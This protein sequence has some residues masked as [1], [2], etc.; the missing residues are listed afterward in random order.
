MKR[1]AI[2]MAASGL[3]S[4]GQLAAQQA[5]DAT[6]RELVPD[7][8]VQNPEDWASQGVPATDIPVDGATDL[9]PDSPLNEM[10]L[11]DIPWPDDADFPAIQPLEPEML[12]EE[13]Q[14]LEFERRRS[15]RAQ[16]E[17]RISRELVLVFPA[18]GSEEEAFPERGDL[19]DRFRSLSTIQRLD[20]EGNVG[21]LAAQAVEDEELLR[22]LLRIYGY[23]DADV[24]RSVI[25]DTTADTAAAA[26][27]DG[28]RQASVRFDILPGQQY[29]VGAIE[30]GD[31]RAAGDD[32]QKLRETF[33]VESGDP[34]S[35]DRIVRGQ[36]DLD[37]A[38]GEA[39]YPF[40]RIAEPELVVDHARE[41]G[42]LTLDVTPGGKYNFGRV[43]SSMPD[44]LSGKHLERIA[45]FD[46]GDLYQRSLEFDLRQA[47]VATGLVGTA[48]VTAVET[49]PPADG[50]PGTVDM[51]VE[52]TP[53]KLRTLAGSIG[54]GSGE[55]FKLQGS[56][57]H[58][59]LFPPEGGLRLRGIAGTREQLAGVTLSKRNFG[60]RDRILTLDA[61]ASTIDFQSY[62]ARTTSVIG[63]FERVSNLLFQK[64]FTYGIGLELVA[65]QEAERKLG[66]ISGP[67][68][69]YFVA[70]VPGQ[71]Q[72]DTS[73]DLLDPTRGYRIGLSASPEYS[74]TQSS[75]F[76]YLKLQFDLAG[77][78]PT[79]DSIVLAGRA[80]AGTIIGAPL[81]AIAPS[82]RFYAGGGGSVRG[83]AYKAIGERA[84]LDST[85]R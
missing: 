37:Q 82:R 7:S 28:Q 26:R 34:L 24:I 77:Y 54:F 46:E 22:R 32:F 21:R 11:I 67:R 31:L 23:Y 78:L 70:A 68:L 65:T 17:I 75:N 71:I 42:D 38:L 62:D 39:G 10:P 8:A 85:L 66:V 33:G 2:L 4:A 25:E 50:Q 45:R 15:L 76:N 59:N 73:N 48:Q 3:I 30:L 1:F 14:F 20:N 18:A 52:L 58:R 63:R 27:P 69:T 55:G 44:F 6:L 43:T 35:S 47:I 60:G 74:R 40:A 41:E 19:I 79:S 83:Y 51:A 84:A 29:R 13:P 9:Q 36:Y 64:P 53:A 80:R 56:W 16:D 72:F 12:A 5:S 61:Y 49:R 57:E 81:G